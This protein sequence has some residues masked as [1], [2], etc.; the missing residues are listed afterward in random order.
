[1]PDR[2]PEE[3]PLL[4]F[5]G[6]CGFCTRAVRW[7]FAKAKPA[8]EA[9][10]YQQLDLAAYD[11]TAERAGHEVLWIPLDGPISGGADGLARLLRTAKTRRWRVAGRVLGAVP[12]RW[13]ARPV[14]RAVARNRHR[15][16][17]GT[18]ACAIRIVSS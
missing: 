15:L 13:S 5:D 2:R 4:V 16:P 9:I 1:M 3:L 8:A 11:T 6:D 17:G 18:E 10:R 14:Y 12:V 7:L